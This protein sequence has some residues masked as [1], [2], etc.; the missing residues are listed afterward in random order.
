MVGTTGAIVLVTI[1]GLLA[2][3]LGIGAG[4]LTCLLLRQSWSLKQCLVDA[5]IAAAMAFAA[6]YVVSAIDS[7]R[8]IWESRV[9]LILA[10][11][12]ASVVVRHLVR[13]AFRS[14][15]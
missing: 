14:T 7:A 13:L 1:N 8:G 15:N 11:A 6:A 9:A 12:V 10:I 4:G 2:S 3:L 5:V